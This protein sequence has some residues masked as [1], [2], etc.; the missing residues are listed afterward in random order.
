[1][2]KQDIILSIVLIIGLFVF[3]LVADNFFDSYIRRVLNPLCHLCHF[4]LIYE[5]DQWFY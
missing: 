3:V 4:G 1:M 2:K 5:P